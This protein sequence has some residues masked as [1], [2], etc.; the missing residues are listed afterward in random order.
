MAPF[1]ALYGRKCRSLLYWDD[2]GERVR[3]GPELVQHAVDKIQVVK[4][5]VKVAHDR[6][7]SYA[8]QR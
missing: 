1:E 5:R 2:V 8:D 4:Q 7:K 6:Y 3:L